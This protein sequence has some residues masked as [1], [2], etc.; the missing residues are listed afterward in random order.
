[1]IW[2]KHY[3]FKLKFPLLSLFGNLNRIRK[4]KSRKE[5]SRREKTQYFYFFVLRFISSIL[6]CCLIFF[7][8]FIFLFSLLLFFYC[9]FDE[10]YAWWM[11]IFR[12]TVSNELG[13]YWL[14]VDALLR[15]VE[16]ACL[17][18]LAAS[19]YLVSHRTQNTRHTQTHSYEMRIQAHE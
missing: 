17:H 15:D 2:N 13:D 10:S 7:V 3:L 6:C 12:E 18:A 1:M 19:S 16:C 14:Q 8:V 4:E 9:R 5:N 11:M